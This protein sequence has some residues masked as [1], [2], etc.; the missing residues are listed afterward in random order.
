MPA[1]NLSEA[2]AALGFKS[3]SSLYR[4]RDAG[5][6]AAYLRPPV[7]TGGAQRLE[8]EPPGLPPLREH[9]ARLIRLQR[10]NE[11]RHDRAQRVNPRWAELAGELTDALAGCSGLQLSAAEAQ[12]LAAALP[13]AMACSWGDAGL[14]WLRVGLADAG[15]WWAGPG[16]PPRPEGTGEFWADAGRWEPAAPMPRGPELWAMVAAMVGG[17]LG[18]PWLQLSPTAAGQLFEQ[19]GEALADIREGARWDQER[20]DRHEVGL[21][22]SDDPGDPGTATWLRERLEAGRLPAD[23]AEQARAWLEAPA[24]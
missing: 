18:G 1:V 7:S 2:A 24:A 6:L 17:M 20:W 22:L 10:N 8:L 16:T 4:L 11:A 9:V 13:A 5:E 15:C 3:R 14:E 19:M 23:L 21:Y 12:A